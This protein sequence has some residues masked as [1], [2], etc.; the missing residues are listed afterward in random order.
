[1]PDFSY[2][3]RS[4]GGENT[5]G[6]IAADTKREV[7]DILARQ[8]LFPIKVELARK[9][10]IEIKWFRRNPPGM[11]VSSTLNQLA[12]LLDNGVPVLMAFQVLVKQ[13]EHPVLKE[14]LADI[15]EQISEGEA[16]DRA[17]AAQGS[18][19]NDLTLS[20]IR[21]GAEGAFLEDA[22]RRTAKFLERQA[23]TN[24]KIVSAMV[25][26]TILLSVGILIV[27]VLLTV[28]VPMF[29]PMFDQVEAQG[30]SLPV[31][32]VLLL[33]TNKCVIRYGVFLLFGAVLLGVLIQAQLAT[34]SGRRFLDT[35][36]LKI[37]V[38][39]SVLLDTAVSRFCRV[40]GTLLENGVPILKALDISSHSTGNAILAAAVRKSAENV[41]AGEPL[42][43][44]LAETGIVP[45]Q[46]MAMI[47]IAEESNTLESVL[48]KIA[49]TIDRR[50]DR[51]MDMLI[52]FIEPVMLLCMATAVF[53]II[54]ALLLPIFQM[55][56]G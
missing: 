50:T 28:F 17:F 45:P 25:Y 30:G 44:P 56:V 9:G 53:G 38:L 16:I 19:F 1:M 49:D 21:A 47:S 36:K 6:T 35:Y 23:E 5:S 3:A 55:D 13:T 37:P 10:Q 18:V 34:P 7:L 48:V 52:R 41:S 11:L 14:V 29:Q 43:K 42:S 2:T 33:E 51:T 39:G 46:V 15:L 26:P 32:T 24:G 31:L 4:I 27:G 12:D 40:L 20:V 8:S 22:L 54:L